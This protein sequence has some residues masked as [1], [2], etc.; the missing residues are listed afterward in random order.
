[1]NTIKN[2]FLTVLLAWGSS[3]AGAVDVSWSG[4]GT[5]GYTRT[6]STLTFDR[7]AND[8]GTL[9][10]DSVLGLQANAEFNPQWSLTLQAVAAPSLSDVSTLEATLPWAYVS[11]RPSNSLLLRAGKMRMPMYVYSENM[12]VGASFES[13][14]VNSPPLGA[15]FLV[16]ERIHSQGSQ[17]FGVAVSLGISSEV[18]KG[19]DRRA[20]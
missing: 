2:T 17:C 19:C 10:R 12:N 18:P 3:S 5:L 7:F 6:D 11:W 1:M 16:D 13:L 4:Y 20:G 8:Q 14:W 15:V 9:K